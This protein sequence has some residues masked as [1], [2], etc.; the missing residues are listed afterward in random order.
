MRIFVALDIEESIRARIQRS[1]E[2][3]QGLAPEVRWVRAASLH[4][5]LKFIGEKPADIVD[6]VKYSLSQVKGDCFP[7][8]FRGYGFFPE[9]K[10]ARVFWL[11]ID[12]PPPLF[13]LAEAVDRAMCALG[14]AK[15]NHAL[16]PHLTLARTG[17]GSPRRRKADG[18][19][20][21]F[22]RLQQRL[23]AIATPDFGEMTV[24]EFFLFQS[25]PS[26]SGPS[27]TKLARFSLGDL[28]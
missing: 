28:Q 10:S 7:I 4:V 27:Y 3:L 2:Q 6:Q 9:A 14:I 22:E 26:S 15:E 13:E 25:Q 16:R 17:A 18:P 5:T 12:A 1:V 20:L 8:S 11:G 19:N 23:P 24:R 21:R